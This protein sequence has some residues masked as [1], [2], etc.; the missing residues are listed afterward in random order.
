MSDTLVRQWHM[1]R[2]LPRAPRKIATADLAAALGERGFEVTRRSIQRDLHKL[3]GFFPITCD[4]QHK[5]YGWS[6]LRDSESFD[7][8]GIDLHAALA[9]RL[10]AEHLTA[11]LPASTRAHLAPHFDRAARLLDGLAAQGLGRWVDRVRVIHRHQPLRA[12]EVDPDILE[13]VQAAVLEGR[14]LAIQYR[15]RGEDAVREYEANP[16]ALVFRDGVP[17]LVATL[18]H[19]TDVMQLVVH[20]V[21]QATLLATPRVEVE[22]FDLDAYIASGGFGFQVGPT[23]LELVLR[24]EARAGAMLYETPLSDDQ[25]VR[26]GTE[27]WL[28]VRATVPDTRQ[29]RVWLRGFGP[30][31][32]VIEPEALR[33]EMQADARR[34]AE[35]YGA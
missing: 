31:G 20:R 7:L 11:L 6:W 3:S 1:L 25:Q 8:P 4:D 13:R 18:W 26:E 21:V 19:Y 34:L 2:L 23:P 22:G 24:V 28:E 9:Y 29:L 5:P 17:Y 10:A 30:L 14:R 33:R 32:E 12:P 35:M 27:G 15:R 16:L